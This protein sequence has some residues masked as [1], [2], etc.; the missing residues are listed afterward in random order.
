MADVA[1]SLSA[2]LGLR[3]SGLNPN[4]G[5]GECNNVVELKSPSAGTRLQ[6]VAGNI[7]G[8]GYCQEFYAA[9]Q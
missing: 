2:V 7:T 5:R 9:L 1:V 6:L 4:G 3:S 8:D